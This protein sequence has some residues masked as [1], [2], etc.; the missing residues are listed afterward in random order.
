MAKYPYAKL[1]VFL[2]LILI[3]GNLLAQV[4]ADISI[5]RLVKGVD[6]R[7][8]IAELNNDG[9]KDLFVTSQV[10]LDSIV[11]L[12]YLQ[13]G[14]LNFAIEDTIHN[15]ASTGFFITDIDNSG[16]ADIIVAKKRNGNGA[17]TALK[18]YIGFTFEE[19][20]LYE[21][22]S[23]VD[24]SIEDFNNDGR[25]DLLVLEYFEGKQE[26]SIHVWKEGHFI[27]FARQE[28]VDKY[29]V[30]SMTDDGFK[31]LLLFSNLK[32]EIIQYRSIDYLMWD[33]VL[34]DYS[35]SIKHWEVTN[36]NHDQFA[37]VLVLSKADEWS[38]DV[39]IKVPSGFEVRSIYNSGS[40][41][42]F[43]GSG[44]FSND[45]LYDIV[46]GT[47]EENK[48]VEL[49]LQGGVVS[50]EPLG[51]PSNLIL[52]S[53]GDVRDDGFLDWSGFS[54]VDD[55]LEVQLY[56]NEFQ[57]ENLGPEYLEVLLPKTIGDYTYFSW[58][59]S[60]DDKT[61]ESAITYDF[62][63]QNENGDML[64]SSDYNTDQVARKGSRDLTRHGTTLFASNYIAK[65]LSSGKYLW[66]VAGVDNAYYSGT[67]I[68]DC[69]GGGGGC[70]NEL[71]KYQCL[72]L[73]REEVTACAME[74]LD[75]NFG[76]EG[77]SV[78]WNSKK[79]GFIGH[80]RSVQYTVT[81]DDE[82]YA[83]AFPKFPCLDSENACVQNLNITV[84]ITTTPPQFDLLESLELEICRNSVYEIETHLPDS[85]GPYIDYTLYLDNQELDPATTEFLV[86]QPVELRADIMFEGCTFTDTLKI[87]T[88]DP[89][90]ITV[91]G[92]S[93]V[94]LGLSTRLTA[95]GAENYIWSP[96]SSLSTPVSAVTQARP[97]ASTIYT[98]QGW[99]EENCPGETT[100]ALEVIPSVFVPELFSPNSDGH[101][102]RLIVHGNDIRELKFSIF[103]SNGRRV[104]RTTSISEITNAGW[105]GRQGGN[106]IP[107]GVYI[108]LV[109]GEFKNGTPVTYQGNNKGKFKVVR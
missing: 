52:S 109:E 76:D 47:K 21:T 29:L 5:D 23:I 44:D 7:S 103:D 27:E 42:E 63:I 13:E 38:V 34:M 8:Q 73:S 81:E 6:Q 74:T 101:N 4:T 35:G 85:L 89:P 53:F 83:V 24:F 25:K 3:S 88:L 57:E 97:P 68:F 48:L 69:K 86:T 54:E 39:L 19:E 37:D 75:L 9:F 70:S 108:W 40:P 79:N 98:V 82:I 106:M 30:T 36:I 43:V 26:F 33:T 41:V 15:L 78:E 1:F 87:E 105:D 94:Y 31:D 67:D 22:D 14:L 102:D 2:F 71:F 32:Q 10:T 60:T 49:D 107:P 100:F 66:G 64:V 95:S 55:S 45:G 50:V 18:N 61:P 59:R 12:L 17:L 92:V 16:R 104:Y 56:I 58:K 77:D 51:L 90:E 96:A 65:A 46:V 84:T 72:T 11:G 28:G 20:V 99:N 93:E 91:D 80:G 62:L